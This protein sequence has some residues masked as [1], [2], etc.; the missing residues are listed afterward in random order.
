ME[1]LQNKFGKKLDKC[2]LCSS[3]KIYHYHTDFNGIDIFR[4][5]NCG[6]QFM[7]PQ[8]S[9]VYLSEYYSGYS[10]DEPQ[11][12]EPLLYCHDYYLSLIEKYVNKGNL[13][14]V[15]SGKGYMLAAAKKRGW[16]AAG[17]DVDEKWNEKLSRK[18]DV[19][20]K[21]GNFLELE[22][23][24]EFNAVVMHHVIEHLKNPLLYIRKIYELL[25]KDG[26]LFLALPN[27]NSRSAVFKRTLEKMGIRKKNTGA[28]YD[29]GHHMFYFTPGSLRILLEHNGY[30]VLTTKSG[31]AARPNQTALKRSFMRNISDRLLWKSTFL[32]ICRKKELFTAI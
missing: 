8:Y 1:Y 21:S 18:L 31:H 4:C 24:T 11:W 22:W 6:V 20:I 27:I 17:Y 25:K 13:L 23:K 32:M 10:V 9:D 30:E 26:V 16:E 12:E 7:N 14:D 5:K 29:T 28:Y 19:E 3:E 15:G 2:I